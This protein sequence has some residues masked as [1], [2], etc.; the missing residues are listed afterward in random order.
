M[1]GSGNSTGSNITGPMHEDHDH[2][3]S[4]H[5]HE[6]DGTTRGL[7]CSLTR[8]SEEASFQRP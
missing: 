6:V 5:T 3:D 2:P 8:R 4:D 1:D 7:R